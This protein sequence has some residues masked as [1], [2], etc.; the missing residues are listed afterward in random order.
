MITSRTSPNVWTQGCWG[1]YVWLCPSRAR[2]LLDKCLAKAC[3]GLALWYDIVTELNT[4]GYVLLL[5]YS[6]LT[7]ALPLTG[8]EQYNYGHMLVGGEG[9]VR[10]LAVCR[11]DFATRAVTWS[12]MSGCFCHQNSKLRPHVVWVITIVC[13]RYVSSLYLW[14]GHYGLCLSPHNM[15]ESLTHNWKVILAWSLY[16]EIG[17][18]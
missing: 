2:S 12:C 5:L 16:I 14:L 6:G 7:L 11:V 13:E 17:N 9:K 4:C 1:P 3:C 15:R 10:Y 18:R 8:Y